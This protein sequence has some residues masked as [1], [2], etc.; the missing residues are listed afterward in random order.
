VGFP[1]I[2][3]QA[4]LQA[5]NYWSATLFPPNTGIAFFEMDQGGKLTRKD[6]IRSAISNT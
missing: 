5:N 1:A 2:S 3:E 4:N 6:R